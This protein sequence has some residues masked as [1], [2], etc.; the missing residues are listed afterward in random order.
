MKFR[1]FETATSKMLTDWS[2]ILITM[3]WD[4]AGTPQVRFCSNCFV[5]TTRFDT[6][7]G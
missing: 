2:H 5:E 7:A 4:G 6:A 3:H 1:V